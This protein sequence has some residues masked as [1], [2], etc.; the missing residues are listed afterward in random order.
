MELNWIKSIQKILRILR[1]ITTNGGT[2]SRNYFYLTSKKSPQSC[3]RIGSS[4]RWLKDESELECTF[5]THSLSLSLSLSNTICTTVTT[6]SLSY[7][8][9]HSQPVRHV[10]YSHAFPFFSHRLPVILIMQHC[11]P[12]WMAQWHDASWRFL[13]RSLKTL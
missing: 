9:S 11:L 10:T 12:P 2:S 13:C 4:T 6:L 5:H 8:V 1:A 3:K 7:Y